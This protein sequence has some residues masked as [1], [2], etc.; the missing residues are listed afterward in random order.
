MQGWMTK[1]TMLRFLVLIALSLGGTAP[2]FAQ[3]GHPALDLGLARFA[4]ATDEPAM[5]LYYTQNAESEH[6]HLVRARALLETGDD[7][8][9][10]RLLD[11]LLNG[12]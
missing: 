12:T 7:K 3:T 9:A 11:Q 5:A 1:T 10:G 4:L 6:D 8:Q 2:T